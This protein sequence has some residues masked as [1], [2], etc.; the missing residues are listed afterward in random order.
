MKTKLLLLLLAFLSVTIVSAQM[1]VQQDENIV[2]CNLD[3]NNSLDLD[4][5]ENGLFLVRIESR[6]GIQVIKTIN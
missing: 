1:T 2:G 4:L 6:K 5:N 3:I